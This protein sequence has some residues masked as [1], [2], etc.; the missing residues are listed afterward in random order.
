VHA[1]LP[2]DYY[3]VDVVHMPESESGHKYLLVLVDVFT[4]FVLLRALRDIQMDAVAAVL[5]EWFCI[6]GPC[7]VM[8]SDNGPE[9]ANQ[10]LEALCKHEGLHHRFITAY[11]P[12]S[13]A[14]V[15]GSNKSVSSVLVKMME[16]EVKY[17]NIFVPL[18]QFVFN[19]KIKDLTRSSPFSLMLNRQPNEFINYTGTRVEPLTTE[20]WKQHQFEV[21]SLVFPALEERQLKLTARTK[22]KFEATRKKLLTAD[23]PAGMEVYIR[24]PAYLKGEPRPREAQRNLGPYYIVKRDYNGPYVLRDGTGSLR[25]VPIDQIIF[26]RAN[27][28]P[29]V[30]ARID[31]IAPIYEVKEIID[32]RFN[33]EDNT[34]EYQV[35]WKGYPQEEATW[36]PI[37]HINDTSLIRE[38]NNRKKRALIAVADQASSSSSSSSSSVSVPEL[39]LRP[40][41]RSDRQRKSSTSTSNR[42]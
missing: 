35:W 8:Q 12:R 37:Q 13:N 38:F 10:V 17:W 32:S 40:R 1:S 3:Q 27:R 26:S 2:G 11:N 5:W 4:G 42:Q 34:M 25:K 15:E 29:A 39:D 24:A 41:R 22:A 19:S 33:E 23:L 18:A 31:E 6:I 16:G 36:E 28:H 14:I 20:N 30:Q 9:F 7:K 21:T